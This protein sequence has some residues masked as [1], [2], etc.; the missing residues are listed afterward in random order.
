MMSLYHGGY[1]S[2]G[3]AGRCNE[4]QPPTEAMLVNVPVHVGGEG[5]EVVVAPGAVEATLS[6]CRL[7]GQSRSTKVGGMY[8]LL[9]KGV[10]P[11]GRQ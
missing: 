7:A 6:R 4:V 10:C 5:Q 9:N 3:K 8:A 11:L 1:Q 2:G